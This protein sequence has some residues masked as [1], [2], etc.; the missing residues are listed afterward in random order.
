MAYQTNT[1][2]KLTKVQGN[3]NYGMKPH[4][5][6]N[7]HRRKHSK[8]HRGLLAKHWGKCWHWL[9]EVRRGGHGRNH[10]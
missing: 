1:H 3:D 9:S 6:S 2:F 8:S 7:N 10:V 4:N 5:M